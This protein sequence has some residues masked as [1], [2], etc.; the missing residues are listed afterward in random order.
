MAAELVEDERFMT[1]RSCAKLSARSTYSNESSWG[2][3]R[4]GNSSSVNSY[5]SLD[6]VPVC[7]SPTL[8]R[9]QLQQ[10]QHYSVHSEQQQQQH[11]EH[12]YL[13]QTEALKRISTK[14]RRSSDTAAKVFHGS[15][16]FS[17][18]DV[19]DIFSYARYTIRAITVG[20]VAQVATV[21]DPSQ[22]IHENI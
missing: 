14:R 18:H 4:R 16:A 13:Q 19:E 17:Q 22:T 7:Q 5:C 12:Q 9:Q 1:P 20:S 21:S 3:S 2:H 10:Q 11:I 6:S 8:E 15:A